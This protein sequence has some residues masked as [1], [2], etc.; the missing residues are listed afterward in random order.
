MIGFDPFPRG[1]MRERGVS[2]LS[3]EEVLEADLLLHVIDA[4]HPN[5]EEQRQVV[6]TV[7]ADPDDEPI[8]VKVYDVGKLFYAGPWPDGRSS[9]RIE[10]A[11]GEWAGPLKAPA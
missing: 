1:E 7:L 2:Y 10:L 8:V 11:F 6:D 3:F 9:V 5:W 4:S